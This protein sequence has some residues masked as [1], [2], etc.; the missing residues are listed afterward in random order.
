MQWDGA[1]AARRQ[2]IVGSYETWMEAR[3][4]V[5]DATGY[6]AAVAAETAAADAFNAAEDDVKL[7]QPRTLAGLARKALCVADLL[8]REAGDDDLG[9]VLA[10]QVAAFGGVVDARP[11]PD[12]STTFDTAAFLADLEAAGCRVRL[13][14]PGTR[15]TGDEAP[16]YFIAPS[17]GY[18]AVMAKWSS[19]IAACPD[20]AAQVTARPAEINAVAA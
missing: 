16:T 8:A 15:F 3:R 6:T 2:E 10:R 19:A 11:E 20:H 12:R 1:A 9:E 7:H 13:E 4:A 18:A 5:E 17:R 14:I